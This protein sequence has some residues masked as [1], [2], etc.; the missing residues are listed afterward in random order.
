MSNYRSR[1]RRY[2]SEPK[3]NVKKVFAVILAFI[4]LIMF[5][6]II[7]GFFN[8]SD[9]EK[10]DIS[11]KSYFTIYKDDKWGV[12]DEKANIVIDPGYKE[13]IV[14]PN[15]KKD[16]FLCTYDVNYDTGEYSTKALNSKNE[17]IFTEY[18]LIEAI[19]NKDEGNNLWYEED[20]LRAKK[21]GKYGLINYE[22]KKIIDFE[23][24]SIVATPGTKN[25]FIIEK[26]G[27]YG[28]ANYKGTILVETKY[29]EVSLFGKDDK[30]GFIIKENGKYGLVDYSLNTILKTKYEKI[31]K[32]NYKNNYYVKENRIK[33]VINAEEKEILVKGFDEILQLSE[34][35]IIIKNNNKVGLIAY[36]GKTKIKTEYE[37]LKQVKENVIIAK[38]REKYGIIDLEENKKVDFIYTNIQYESKPDLYIADNENLESDILNNE[39]EIK[40]HGMLVDLNIEEG[41]LKIIQNEEKKYYTFKFEEEKETDILKNNTLYAIKKDGKYGFSNKEGNIIVDTIYEEVTEQNKYGFA[42]IKKEG[43]WGVVDSKGIIIQEPIYDLENYFLID[44]IGRWHLGQEV[45]INYYNQK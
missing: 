8:K 29:D 1:G 11:C 26:E 36:D 22:N 41:Y 21:D 10:S 45:N 13:M 19:P 20:V 5:I 7:K 42:G 37:D 6:Y 39:F 2:D 30:S 23:Y 18:D 40:L 27:K 12:I 44:F 28:I 3:L 15:P 16:I 31:Y 25:T 24:D 32:E 17:E 34:D 14:I 43:K 9:G 35:G 33:K 4:V 38:K